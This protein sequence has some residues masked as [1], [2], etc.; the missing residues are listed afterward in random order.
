MSSE[1]DRAVLMA[2]K[3]TTARQR[4]RIKRKALERRRL[5]TMRY[6]LTKSA[7]LGAPLAYDDALQTFVDATD[8]WRYVDDHRDR[9]RS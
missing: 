8:G 6:R 1:S 5:A 3:W 9:G 7:R 4:A 2:S